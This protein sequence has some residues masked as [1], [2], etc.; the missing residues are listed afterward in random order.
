MQDVTKSIIE[1]TALQISYWSIIT[2]KHRAL[3]I[4]SI[5]WATWWQ[6][7]GVQRPIGVRGALPAMTT[8]ITITG[9]DYSSLPTKQIEYDRSIWVRTPFLRVD[10]AQSPFEATHYGRRDLSP[11]STIPT[12]KGEVERQF[13]SQHSYDYIPS[14]WAKCAY[15]CLPVHLQL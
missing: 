8:I 9:R 3:I 11:E 5:N 12:T 1:N 6:W 7:R 2:A 10:W 15:L 4:P 14:N 13:T